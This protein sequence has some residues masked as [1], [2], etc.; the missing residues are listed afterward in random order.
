M[1]PKKWIHT[2]L[3]GFKKKVIYSISKLLKRNRYAFMNGIMSLMLGLHRRIMTCLRQKY[4]H[5]L[6]LAI[7]TKCKLVFP[8][9]LELSLQTAQT[10][11][12]RSVYLDS[13]V[14]LAKLNAS[15]GI[16]RG[17]VQQDLTVGTGDPVGEGDSVEVKYTGWL[18][19]SR[20]FGSVSWEQLHHQY[21]WNGK[22]WK[23]IW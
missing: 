21:L 17:V 10:K 3:F 12:H 2:F 20:A 4:Y 16:T 13:Q 9:F 19:Q 11:R 1:S 22:F 5:A 8:K 6:N 15:G 18:Y 14:G 7:K 23:N